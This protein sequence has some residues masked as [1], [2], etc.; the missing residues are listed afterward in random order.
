MRAFHCF[1]VI[2]VSIVA[3]LLLLLVDRLGADIEKTWA[4]TCPVRPGSEH[5]VAMCST[6]EKLGYDTFVDVTNADLKAGFTNCLVTVSYSGLR[7]S[8][9]NLDLKKLTA[10]LE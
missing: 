4:G 7:S 5:P 10:R 8:G 2:C 3:T 6:T 1:L 9:C